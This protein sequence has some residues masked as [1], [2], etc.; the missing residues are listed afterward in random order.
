MT[1]GHIPHDTSHVNIEH[2]DSSFYSGSIPNQAF[3]SELAQLTAHDLSQKEY[4]FV[5]IRPN[6]VPRSI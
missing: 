6:G 2:S 1:I 5:N 4:K 3:F